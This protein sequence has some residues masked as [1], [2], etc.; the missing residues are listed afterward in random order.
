MITSGS[1][2]VVCVMP[3]WS[4][5]SALLQSRTNDSPVA[6]TPQKGSRERHVELCNTRMARVPKNDFLRL[7]SLD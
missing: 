5:K 3:K 4:K 6:R 2:I 1:S 7:Q